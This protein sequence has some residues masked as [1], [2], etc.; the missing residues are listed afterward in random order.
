M[1]ESRDARSMN[2]P[3]TEMAVSALRFDQ[4]WAQWQ[5]RG[6]RHDARVARNMWLIWSS[7][8]IALTIGV[9]WTLFLR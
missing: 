4:R 1:S 5:E 6:A 3:L 7:A 2:R 8:G 9:I